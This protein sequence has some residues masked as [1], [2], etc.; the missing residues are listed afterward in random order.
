MTSSR[1]AVYMR[2]S[3]TSGMAELRTVGPVPIT[4]A[5]SPGSPGGSG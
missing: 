2:V 1:R 3:K 5:V 4:C